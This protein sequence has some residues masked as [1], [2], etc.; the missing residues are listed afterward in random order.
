MEPP[1]FAMRS[2]KPWL[3]AKQ[4]TQ[5]KAGRDQQSVDTK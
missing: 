1:L 3:L 4:N 2:G 5:V